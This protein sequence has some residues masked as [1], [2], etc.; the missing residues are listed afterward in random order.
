ME[1]TTTKGGK[2]SIGLDEN[3]AGLLAYLLGFITGILFLVLEKENKFVRFH[4][5]QSLVTFGA[6]FVLGFVIGMIPLLGWLIA[7]LISILEI[8]FWILGMV[9]AFKGE[10]YKFPVFGNIAE[11]QLNK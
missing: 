4:A 10:M 1:K 5:M 2:T 9:K 11:S 8:V 6:L 7:F 3:V